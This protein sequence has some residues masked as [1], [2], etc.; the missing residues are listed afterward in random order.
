D[1]YGVNNVIGGT[2]PDARNIISGNGLSPAIPSSQTSASGI[3]ARGTG[4]LIEGNYIR[5]DATGTIALGNGP[6]VTN[7]GG[8]AIY[9]TNDAS[10]T[11]I[12]GTAPG[13]GNLISGNGVGINGLN[14]KS[15]PLPVIQG[16]LIGTDV[17][18]TKPLGNGT[19]ISLDGTFLIGGTT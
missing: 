16:N 2:T 1:S 7:Y 6:S 17:T 3:W 10:N 4:D 13:A 14:F 19:G 18:G 5:T 9:V 15:G 12:G 11:T 8:G